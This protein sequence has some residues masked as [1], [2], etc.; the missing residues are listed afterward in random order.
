MRA[1]SLAA[2]LRLAVICVGVTGPILLGGCTFSQHLARSAVDYNHSVEAA[3]NEILLTNVIRASKHHPMVFSNISILRG[4]VSLSAAAKLT[5]PFR[6]P[7]DEFTGESTLAVGTSP[8]VDIVPLI[9]QEFMRGL[10]A[11]VAPEILQH[12]WEHNWSR[13]LLLNVL[14]EKVRIPSPEAFDE[15][16]NNPEDAGHSRQFRELMRCFSKQYKL[17]IVSGK[18]SIGPPVLVDLT[19]EPGSALKAIEVILKAHE[20]KLAIESSGEG[21]RRSYQLVGPEKDILLEPLSPTK[22]CSHLGAGSS[23]TPVAIPHIRSLRGHPP[24]PSPTPTDSPR[25]VI[26]LRSADS[27]LRYL[28]AI[29]RTRNTP[30]IEPS[31]RGPTGPPCAAGPGEDAQRD[32]LFRVYR[33][34]PG[35]EGSLVT[36]NYQGERFYV[37]SA[38]VRTLQ[39]IGLVLQILSLNTS[40][41]DL[42]STPTVIGVGP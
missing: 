21:P 38:E 4:N 23:A 29:A 12:Y 16:W 10:L 5:M 2:T 41:K 9:N 20:H 11:E 26:F 18:A 25:F 31:G 39:T 42:P 14:I 36:V 37:P 24:E 32:A 22:P 3:S 35:P 19:G 7:I 34:R 33:G 40:I 13:E 1:R 8:S 27:V 6:G 17:Q 28:G 30:C 15:I